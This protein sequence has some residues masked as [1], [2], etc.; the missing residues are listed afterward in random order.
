MRK[1]KCSGNLYP[2]HDVPRPTKEP[3]R[4]FDHSTLECVNPN[5]KF[6]KWFDGYGLETV[7]K[8]RRIHKKTIAKFCQEIID[9]ME[10]K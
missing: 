2:Y 5:S 1:Y 6:Q 8:P 7:V 10:G 9:Y 4:I 3:V